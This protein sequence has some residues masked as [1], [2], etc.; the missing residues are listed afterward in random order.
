MVYNFYT[1]NPWKKLGCI[2]IDLLKK[3]I[4]SITIVVEMFCLLK[5]KEYLK[6]LTRLLHIVEQFLGIYNSQ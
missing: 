2:P 6:V 3:N 4:P 1:P 5:K